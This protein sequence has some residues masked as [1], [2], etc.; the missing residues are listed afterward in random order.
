MFFVH[1]HLQYH[2]SYSRKEDE[3]GQA[4]EAGGGGGRTVV[5]LAKDCDG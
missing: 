5:Q 4:A 2:N 3:E 1:E